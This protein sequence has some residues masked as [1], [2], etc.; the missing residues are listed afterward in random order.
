ME[1]LLTLLILLS[2]SAT[3]VILNK[4]RKSKFTLYD[5]N[6]QRT[7]PIRGLLALLIIIHHSS[8]RVTE[9]HLPIIGSFIYWGGP[10]LGVFF[11]L[12]GYGLMASYMKKQNA[13]LSDFISHRFLRLLPAFIIATTA[14]LS[15]FSIKTD[16]NAFVKITKL[17]D[18]VT[19]LP[20]SWFV[21]A[22]LL[23]YLMFYFFARILKSPN[24]LMIAMWVFSLLY[25]E[26]TRHYN[27]GF[28]WYS[29]IFSLNIGICFAVYERRIK[30]ILYKSH[31]V[32]LTFIWLLIVIET[33]IIS[34]IIGS[35][36]FSE[37]PFN[38]IMPLSVVFFVYVLG[39]RDLPILRAI[40]TISYE[41]YLVQGAIANELMILNYNLILYLCM[42]IILSLVC[43]F[44]LKKISTY[45][46]KK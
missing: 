24:K 43:G 26:L 22:V 27:W 23:S 35:R 36:L 37:I 32:L 20:T 14:Y 6:L 31:W 4:L 28:W 38:A 18:G 8:Q 1:L 42:V 10:I 30:Q 25:A 11:F 41:V 13:Y 5:F 29:S 7:L 46:F 44:V 33:F 39:M 17:I 3:F 9:L 34:G 21:Y 2:V 15:Y 16:T 19:P 12:T 40:G 45:P